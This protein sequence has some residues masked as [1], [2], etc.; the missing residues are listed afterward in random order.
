MTLKHVALK[1]LLGLLNKL[2]QILKLDGKNDKEIRL[3]A[4]VI[5]RFY[6]EYVYADG[7]YTISDDRLN[8][9]DTFKAKTIK[10]ANEIF[11]LEDIS[12]PK[13]I[14]SLNAKLTKF[15][16]DNEPFIISWEFF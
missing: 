1:Y 15:W 10:A 9:K 12:D 3:L 7:N 4:E 2:V 11:Q 5:R 6:H 14:K 16:K 13:S 8:I